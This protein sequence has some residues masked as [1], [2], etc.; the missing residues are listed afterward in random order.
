ME[1][2][3]KLIEVGD[4]DGAGRG[5]RIECNGE[6]VEIIGLT[7]AELSGMPNLLYR[8][9]RLSVVAATSECPVCGGTED[10]HYECAP[11]PC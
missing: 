7:V 6:T 9:V 4:L 11:E 1:F 8:P 10:S 2:T 3:G 5:I